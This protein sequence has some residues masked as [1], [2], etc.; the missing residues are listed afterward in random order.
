MVCVAVSPTPFLSPVQVGYFVSIEIIVLV[1][2]WQSLG[3]KV[4]AKGRTAIGYQVLLLALWFG[5]YCC[6]GILSMVFAG[7]VF[8]IQGCFPV[9]LFYLNALIGASLGAIIAFVIVYSLSDLRKPFYDPRV[10]S[11]G[12][13]SEHGRQLTD[14]RWENCPSRQP[15]QRGE[16]YR[17]DDHFHQ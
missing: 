1:L 8:K 15:S 10:F 7:R 6:G 5:G 13:R 17:K 12:L 16:F 3:N 14:P 9:G 2:L 11:Q 4:R